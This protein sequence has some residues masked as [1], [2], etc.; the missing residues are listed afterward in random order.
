MGVPALEIFVETSNQWRRMQI[1]ELLTQ[2]FVHPCYVRGMGPVWI[3]HGCEGDF[4]FLATKC[5]QHHVSWINAVHE[6]WR[7]SCCV[8]AFIHRLVVKIVRNIQL[9][10]N[11]GY[12]TCGR[13]I[14][15]W[16]DTRQAHGWSPFH[17][18]A[19]VCNYFSA[20][21]KPV[22]NLIC[23]RKKVSDTLHSHFCE[24]VSSSV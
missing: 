14:F 13:D 4:I 22:F 5:G 9:L 1:N 23:V 12:N 7:E 24:I 18:L 19:S 3:M 21:G 6:V 17:R 10:Q 2:Y 16:L 15:V 11:G 20:L 8:F